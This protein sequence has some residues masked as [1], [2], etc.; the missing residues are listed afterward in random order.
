MI[1]HLQIVRPFTVID[2][3][4]TGV[5]P[6]SDRIVEI[7]VVRFAPKVLPLSYVR[8]VNPG[9]SIPAAA[10]AVHGISNADVAGCP[11]FRQIAKRLARFLDDSDLCGY[12]IKRFDLPLLMA[13]FR[14]SSVEFAIRGRA[15][16]DVW[17]IFRNYERRD[18]Q[19]A[20]RFY[21]GREIEH[22]HSAT[23]DSS[24]TAQI[25]D[26]MLVRYSCL[27][28]TVPELHERLTEVDLG[29]WFRR[30]EGTI[31][32][33]MGKYSGRPLTEIASRTPD[34]LRWILTQPVLDDVRILI[35]RALDG[36][37]SAG[38]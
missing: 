22:A 28:R 3:E 14:R 6:A 8:R 7:G 19:A 13:E 17:Q 23:H 16:V 15:V 30:E 11:A 9:V 21:C 20:F 37:G 36:T 10:S 4:T 38:P 5:D 34:Y 24:A 26:A 18:L 32:F 29:G 27:P 31:V 1:E 12:N 35:A 33:A 2:I 25:L